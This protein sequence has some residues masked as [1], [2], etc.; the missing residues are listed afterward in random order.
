MFYLL[1]IIFVLVLWFFIS[2]DFRQVDHFLPDWQ[3]Y[4]SFRPISSLCPSTSP[5]ASTRTCYI[6]ENVADPTFPGPSHLESDPECR[7]KH[8]GAKQCQRLGFGYQTTPAAP[9][10][11]PIGC[12][13]APPPTLAR[14][15][16]AKLPPDRPIPCR[17]AMLRLLRHHR[18][19]KASPKIRWRFP[20]GPAQCTTG[21]SSPTRP[22]WCSCLIF[23]ASLWRSTACTCGRSRFPLFARLPDAT[24]FPK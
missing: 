19:P 14:Y 5:T 8:V 1:G 6:A 4:L 7:N 21:Q 15:K 13:S 2:F 9:L 16:Q 22:V 12:L 3:V 17:M 18:P 20:Q 11:A 23:Y 10:G 24:L